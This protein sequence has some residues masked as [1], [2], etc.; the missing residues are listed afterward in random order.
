MHESFAIRAIYAHSPF[1][2]PLL[3]W[4]AAAK[5]LS[6]YALFAQTRFGEFAGRLSP[7]KN[8]EMHAELARRGARYLDW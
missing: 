8:G 1:H 4:S 2:C 5:E 7:L 3:A 6:N